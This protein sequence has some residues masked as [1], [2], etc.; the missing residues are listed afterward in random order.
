M[1]KRSLDR[2]CGFE[3]TAASG[4]TLESAELNGDVLTLKVFEPGKRSYQFLIAIERSNRESKVEAPLLAVTGAQ[5]ET[6]ELLVEGWRDGV[7][8]A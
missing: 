3:L 8:R 6:G 4:T 2:F 7:D 1:V 5:R